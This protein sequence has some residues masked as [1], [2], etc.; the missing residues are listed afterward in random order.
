M[1][2]RRRAG[3]NWRKALSDPSVIALGV[4][5]AWTCASPENIRKAL[6]WKSAT[7]EQ[8]GVAVIARHGFAGPDQWLQLD[9]SLN[10][11]PAD[12]MW[13]V[14]APVCLD[15]A[16]TQSMPVYTA[17]WYAM[18]LSS[19]T[20]YNRQAQQTAQYLQATSG[21]Q[22]HVFVGDLNV[23]EGRR[24]SATRVPNN[25]ALSSLRAAGYMDAWSTST[26]RRRDIR[27]WSTAPGAAMPEGYPFKRIDYAWTP[28][29]FPP[30]AHAAIRIVTPG[31]ASPSDHFGVVVTVP[32]PGTAAPAHRLLGARRPPPVPRR[33]ATAVS[34][35]MRGTRLWSV[36]LGEWLRT[37]PQQAARASPTMM[38]A[39]PSWPPRLP[40][41]QATSN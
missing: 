37:P 2:R 7:R 6:G 28:A 17:H 39:R 15:A 14:R 29:S 1:G 35:S 31:D 5:E 9:T 33:R 27:A 23:W 3:A 24:Q 40:H 36:G 13:V 41:P 38:P 12:T 11:N 8:N 26:A 10:T 19:A 34:C 25:I 30:I 20:S 21:G 32:Y 4:N 18:G 22:P 16:C